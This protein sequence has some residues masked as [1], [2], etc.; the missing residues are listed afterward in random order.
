[1][2][3]SAYVAR[4]PRV[5]VDGPLVVVDLQPGPDPGQDEGPADLGP[6]AMGAARAGS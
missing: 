3:R 5:H 6:E 2:A 4:W 1:V